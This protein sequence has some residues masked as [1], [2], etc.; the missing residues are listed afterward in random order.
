MSTL[1]RLSVE[2]ACEI[3]AS[4]AIVRMPYFD[5]VRV[6]TFGIG[7][8]AAAGGLDPKS[9]PMGTEQPMEKVIEVFKADIANNEKR[10]A[11][12][13]TREPKQHEFDAA[14]SFDINT[15]AAPRASWLKSFNAGNIAQAG[16]EFM[17]WSRP[18]EII[19]RRQRERDLFLNGTYTSQGFANAYPANA[20]GQ[21]QWSRGKRINIIGM[22]E[23]LFA[24]KAAEKQATKD[25]NSA[26]GA[27]AAGTASGVGGTVTTPDPAA[28]PAPDAGMLDPS[29]LRV[30]MFV[31]GG[32]LLIAAVA[33]L[34][35]SLSNRR[36]GAALTREAG[37]RLASRL[38]VAQEGSA[39]TTP[40][41]LGKALPV[42]EAPADE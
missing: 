37:D 5:S 4:E 23:A 28:T 34:I 18:P 29:S 36:K 30:F 42:P 41:F 21:V 9:L 32:L 3:I 20:A 26:G 35:R 13:M 25:R 31:I 1:D 40:Q 12:A 11:K 16:R 27:T 6:L 8:T 38:R 2:G 24:A 19:P 14:V 17:N 33:F 7:H 22:V 39:P 10:V 15:G